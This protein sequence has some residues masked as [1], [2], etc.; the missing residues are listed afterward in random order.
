MRQ[1]LNVIKLDPLG[2][3]D[4]AVAEAHGKYQPMRLLVVPFFMYVCLCYV[5]IYVCLHVW[6]HICVQVYVCACVRK[7]EVEVESSLDCFLP[8]GRVSQLIPHR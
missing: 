2:D 4:C 3:G 6:G 8:W 5:C 1:L 7:P